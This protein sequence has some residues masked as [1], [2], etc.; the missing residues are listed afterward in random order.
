MVCFEQRNQVTARYE[1]N[2]LLLYFKLMLNKKYSKLKNPSLVSVISESGGVTELN[3]TMSV[4]TQDPTK[5]TFIA[6]SN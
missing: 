6:V 1:L 4:C 5:Q 3:R 2:N